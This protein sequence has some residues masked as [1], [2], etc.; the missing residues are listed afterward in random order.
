MSEPVPDVEALLLRVRE[1]V[2]AGRSMP[3]SA[4]VLVN[5]DELLTLIDAVLDELPEELRQARW[6]LKERE[7]FLAQAR[8]DADTIVEAARARA[9]HLVERTE[10]VR[11]ARRTAQQVVD[12]ADA[13][14]RRLHHEAEDYIDQKLAAF[15]ILLN[16]TLQTV[17]R[18]R[19][20]LRGTNKPPVTDPNGIPAVDSGLPGSRPQP[21][22]DA[23]TYD[24]ALSEPVR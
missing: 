1:L 9:E 5:R 15:E 11:E 20:Q 8:R 6:L 14:A 12:E 16:K 18:G 22:F 10:I 23:E 24:P 17:S 19:E 2:D 21:V 13:T 7:E 3:M 4:S